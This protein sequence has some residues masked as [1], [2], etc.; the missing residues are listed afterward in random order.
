MPFTSKFIV[1]IEVLAEDPDEEMI[2]D[3]FRDRSHATVAHKLSA[4]ISDTTIDT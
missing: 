3:P 1:L 4:C 2:V